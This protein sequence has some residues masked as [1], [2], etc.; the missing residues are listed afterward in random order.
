MS[1][2]GIS[3]VLGYEVVNL[4]SPIFPPPQIIEDRDTIEFDVL[5]NHEA[6]QKVID[7]LT[8]SSL[9]SYF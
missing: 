8:F 7:R 3:N 6:Q 4:P 2:S 9:D 5:V 1:S